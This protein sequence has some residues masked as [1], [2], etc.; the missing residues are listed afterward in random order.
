MTLWIKITI[1]FIVGTLVNLFV[2]DLLIQKRIKTMAAALDSRIDKLNTIT[3]DLAGRLTTLRQELAAAQAKNADAVSDGQLASLDAIISHLSA[4]GAD[5][6]DP[7][8]DAP[9]ATPAP[10]ATTVTP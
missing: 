1:A 2:S 7:V 3:N 8:P 5:P 6:A 10:D 4:I 9:P